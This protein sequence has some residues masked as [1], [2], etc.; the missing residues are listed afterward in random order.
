MWVCAASACARGTDAPP[1]SSLRDASLLASGVALTLLGSRNERTLVAVGLALAGAG[2]ALYALCDCCRPER[3][4]PGPA[5]PLP[6]RC[7]R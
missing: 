6:S 5:F 2:L 4:A 1:A 7:S 3:C